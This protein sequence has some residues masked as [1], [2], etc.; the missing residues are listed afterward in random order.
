MQIFI[1]P[2]SLSGAMANG[3]LTQLLHQVQQ[4][5]KQ[6]LDEVFPLVYDE[7]HRL[8][9]SQLRMERGNHTL[10]PTALV[11]EAYLRLIS[12]HNVDWRN[13]AHFFS[14]AAEMM[15]RILVNYA[16]QRNA[17]KRGNGEIRLSLDEAVDFARKQ[18][19]D[20]VLLDESLRR[21]AALDPQKAKIVELRFFGGL[22]VEEV[23]EVTGLSDSTVKRQWRAAKAWLH[24]QISGLTFATDAPLT[25]IS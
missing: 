18:D 13:R 20:L 19:V 12:Q 8:A 21:L 24:T 4:G 1:P 14:I 10:Q 25:N 7:L 15:R 23:A 9:S 3:H 2:D 5:D 16:M 11:N 6:V 22:S 17:V